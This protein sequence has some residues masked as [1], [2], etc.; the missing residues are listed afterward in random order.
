MPIYEYFCPKCQAEFELMRPV[1][2][3]TEP[4]SCPQC[5]SAG[6]KLVSVFGSKTGFYVR[7]PEKPAFRRQSAG[8]EKK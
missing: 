5:G 2:Q 7:A 1:S 3:A 8:E 6:Q 4:A